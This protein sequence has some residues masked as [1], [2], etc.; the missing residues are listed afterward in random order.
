[1]N[2]VAINQA[3]TTSQIISLAETLDGLSRLAKKLQEELVLF[4]P[5]R[6]NSYLK[7]MQNTILASREF[8]EEESPTVYRNAKDLIADLNNPKTS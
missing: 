8:K 5:A 4:L 3:A 7:L 1:M 2:G 6:K